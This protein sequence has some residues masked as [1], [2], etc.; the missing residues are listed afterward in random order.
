MLVLAKAPSLYR[1]RVTSSIALLCLGMCFALVY[2][3]AGLRALG[4]ILPVFVFILLMICL[5]AGVHLTADSIAREKRE[6]TIGLLL[7]TNLTPLQIV[8]G[9]LMAHALMGFYS[10]LIIVPLLSLITIAGGLRVIEIAVIGL[11]A[12]NILFFSAAVGLW[13]S[14]RHTDRKK[15]AAAGTW[16]VLFF[17]WGIPVLV[18]ALHRIHAPPWLTGF[19]S[20][21]SVNQNFSGMFMGR[22]AVMN[23][24]WLNILVAHLMGWGF[25]FLSAWFL[26]HRWQD[27][28]AKERFS[29][30]EWWRQKSLGSARVRLR[31]RQRLLER[32]PFLWLA[33]RDRLRHVGVWIIT[34]IMLGVI[35]VQF[36][37]GWTASGGMLSLLITMCFVHKVMVAAISAH[38]LGVE[39]EQGTLEMLLSTPLKAETVLRGQIM[40]TFRQFRGPMV[41]WAATHVALVIAILEWEPFGRASDLSGT[42]LAVYGLIHLLE[43]YAMTWAGMWGAVTVKEAK[44]AAGAAMAR[45]IAIP[46]LFFGLVVSGFTSANWYFRLG[47]N[48][49]PEIIV[50][51]YFLLCIVNAFFWLARLQMKLPGAVREF[52]LRRYT[53]EESNSIWVTIGRAAGRFWGKQRASASPEL[54][55]AGRVQN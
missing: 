43:L 46:G 31:L 24:P 1:N 3:Y 7:L 14:A 8:F 37:Y 47:L 32:N 26:K 38:Q 22:A 10:I 6:G 28:P 23:Q 12:M 16:V 55:V 13:A 9:K 15:A 4:Q 53:P 51:F 5:F 35:V 33:S 30:R 48:F 54:G 19:I 25:V 39:Q 50:G 52:A 18:D 42:A 44:N 34:V 20:V 17:W 27:V 40:A 41:L 21:F 49:K 36:R 11:A 2:E 45:I 29:L